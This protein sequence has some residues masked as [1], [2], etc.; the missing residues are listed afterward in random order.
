MRGWGA[1]SGVVPQHSRLPGLRRA[2]MLKDT[3]TRA[4]DTMERTP[5]VQRALG[6]LSRWWRK[7]WELEA[8]TAVRVAEGAGPRR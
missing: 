1:L 3:N 8:R 2:E 6:A 5:A 7:F 4:R